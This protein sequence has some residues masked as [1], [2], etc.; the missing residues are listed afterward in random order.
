D[1]AIGCLQRRHH[2]RATLQRSCV[3]KG[4]D[5]DIDARAGLDEGRHIGGD[6]DGRDISGA[7]LASLCRYTEVLQHGADGLLRERRIAQRI[8]SALQADD[9][10]VAH[11]LVVTGALELCNIL[12]ARRD[13]ARRE[14]TWSCRHL[15]QARGCRCIIVGIVEGAAV[16]GRNGLPGLCSETVGQHRLRRQDKGCHYARD[17]LHDAPTLMVPSAMTVPVN[18]LPLS[19]LRTLTRS[20]AAPGCNVTAVAEMVRAPDTK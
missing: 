14:G 19:M 12:D 13:L 11:Q 17:A 20:P 3:A 6:D 1:L 2:Q 4:R 5:V 16:L 15:K 8:A 18:T 7:R 9:Q 10:A